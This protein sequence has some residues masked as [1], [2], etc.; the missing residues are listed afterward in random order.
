MT[1][2][3]G[4]VRFGTFDAE[5]HWRPTDLAE[6][7]RLAARGA[8]PV[9]AGLDEMLFGLTSPD[10]LL[11][12]HNPLDPAQREALGAAGFTFRHLAARAGPAESVEEALLR[13]TALRR[14][15][16]GQ[17]GLSPFAVLPATTKLAQEMKASHGLPPQ[18]TVVRVNGKAWSSAVADR[19]GLPG[20]GQV[21]RSAK[22][23]ESAVDAVLGEPG[24]G[25]A[26]VKDSYGV[27]GRGTL[28][29]ATPRAL[30]RLLRHLRA[31]EERG[32]RIEFVVQD[33]YDR[34]QDFSAHLMINED[35]SWHRLGLQ[36]MSNNGY[37]HAA[38]LPVPHRLEVELARREY[39]ALLG[40][41]AQELAA[42]GYFGPVGID[43]MTLRDG[44]W[45][46]VVEINARQSIGLLNLELDRRARTHGLR[47][48]LWQDDV[49]VAPGTG[50]DA[51]LTALAADG[52]LYTGGGRAGVLP[53]VGS[54]ILAPRG[55]L[56]CAVFC[57]PEDFSSWRSY[58]RDCARRAGIDAGRTSAAESA[59]P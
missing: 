19:M 10:D 51:L 58:T 34:D 42:E 50:I 28:E 23:L 31:Q 16:A 40:A 35:G 13:D 15:V 46:P 43:S 44:S 53:L 37:R 26:L 8:D 56:V 47:S 48:H 29:I 4:A 9:V 45:V 20:A 1:A 54:A 32:A 41:V 7:P 38:S 59:A 18:E 33:R 6:L 49:S 2:S 24:D 22:E 55:R 21:V 39:G 27:A 17:G 57:P 30:A 5:Q 36:R 12:T 25:I 52:L 3:T 14:S 11:I